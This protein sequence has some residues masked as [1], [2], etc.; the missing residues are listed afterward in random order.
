VYTVPN[1]RKVITESESTVFCA[2]KVKLSLVLI[3]HHAIYTIRISGGGITTVLLDLGS[4][5]R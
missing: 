4:R 2:T 1:L 5:L 3:K